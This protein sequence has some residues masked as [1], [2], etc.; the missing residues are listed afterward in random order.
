MTD[1]PKTENYKDTGNNAYR[2]LVKKY[3]NGRRLC[4][5]EKAYR[6]L[7]GNCASGCDS[8]L[9]SCRNEIAQK[10]LE[11]LNDRQT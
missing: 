7:D 9:I 11:E 1:K 3:A 10:V 4:N 2:E 8:N 5:C 6:N